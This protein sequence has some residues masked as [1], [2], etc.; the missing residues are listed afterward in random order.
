MKFEV[1]ASKSKLSLEADNLMTLG[2]AGIFG[3]SVIVARVDEYLRLDDEE[4]GDRARV[5]GVRME[6]WLRCSLCFREVEDDF[7]PMAFAAFT[8]GKSLRCGS[9]KWLEPN[10]EGSVARDT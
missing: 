2:Q 8:G 10:F 1:F 5:T 3:K 6:G 4:E 7:P 9:W